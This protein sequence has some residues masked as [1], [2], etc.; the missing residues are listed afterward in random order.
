MPTVLAL[1]VFAVA[2]VAVGVLVWRRPVTALYCF[3]VG[4]AAHNLVMALLWG[5]GVRG[6]SLELISAWKEIL[7][8]VAVARVALDAAQARRLPVQPGLVDLLAL[9]FGGFVLLYA[10]IPQSSLDGSADASA[11]LHA[12]RHDLVPVVAFLLGLVA[13]RAALVASGRE[14]SRCLALGIRVGNVRHACNGWC[15][16]GTW[17]TH[18]AT[19]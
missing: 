19:W 7:L 5:A 4:L 11:V 17:P 10:V 14:F 13:R 12:L 18:P 3:V 15:Q 2:I 6:S 9:C 16:S 8:A 1:S